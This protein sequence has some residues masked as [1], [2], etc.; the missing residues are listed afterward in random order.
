MEI[1]EVII[2]EIMKEIIPDIMEVIEKINKR[3]LV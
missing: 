3:N 2:L 1:M